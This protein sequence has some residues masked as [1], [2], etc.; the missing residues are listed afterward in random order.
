VAKD[1]AGGRSEPTVVGVDG[2]FD[3]E[4]EHRQQ[5][6]YPDEGVG[7]AGVQWRRQRRHLIQRRR[8]CSQP[9]RGE[10]GSILPLGKHNESQPEKERKAVRRT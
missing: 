6:K 3:G 10:G 4:E 2:E 9:Q 7:H 5:E 1:T 8:P